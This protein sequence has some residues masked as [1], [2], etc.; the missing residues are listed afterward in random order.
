MRLCIFPCR[1]CREA[2]SLYGSHPMWWT[3][4]KSTWAV[5]CSLWPRRRHPKGSDRPTRLLFVGQSGELGDLSLFS[6]CCAIG[7]RQSRLWSFQ[8]VCV[9]FRWLHMMNRPWPNRSDCLFCQR[10]A[11][12]MVC[13]GLNTRSAHSHQSLLAVTFLTI[14]NQLY[15]PIVVQIEWMT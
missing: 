1:D 12:R 14:I 5:K 7:C 6:V 15:P 4:H 8:A 2:S 11:V 9:L 3:T 10:S 13:Q